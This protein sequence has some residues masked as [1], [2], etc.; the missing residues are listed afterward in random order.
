[1]GELLQILPGNILH[2]CKLQH[3]IKYKILDGSKISANRFPR[4]T[5]SRPYVVIAGNS[6]I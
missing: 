6:A 2:V 1:M 3:V 5:F 4:E